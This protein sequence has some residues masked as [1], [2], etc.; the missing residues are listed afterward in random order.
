[1]LST[2][3]ASTRPKNGAGRLVFLRRFI[4]GS[5]NV[6]DVLSMSS[7]VDHCKEIHPRAASTLSAGGMYSMYLTNTYSKGASIPGMDKRTRASAF[8]TQT[9]SLPLAEVLMQMKE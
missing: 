5:E 9:H 4:W 7:D 8:A 6:V 3:S 1:M 2:Q